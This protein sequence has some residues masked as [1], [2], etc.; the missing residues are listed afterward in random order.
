MFFVCTLCEF[1]PQGS[2]GVV[3]SGGGHQFTPL[4][5]LNND[6]FSSPVYGISDMSQI[7]AAYKER[8]VS[9]R[10]DPNGRHGKT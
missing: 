8:T 7:S 4:P 9:R 1:G 3:M 5:A 2:R 6:S 10:T